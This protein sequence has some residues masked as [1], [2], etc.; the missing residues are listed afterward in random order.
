MSILSYSIFNIGCAFT[1]SPA[2]CIYVQ[3]LGK[4]FPKVDDHDDEKKGNMASTLYTSTFY[5]GGLLGFIFG[6]GL[7]DLY[8]FSLSSTIIGITRLLFA[9][10]YFYYGGVYYRGTGERRKHDIINFT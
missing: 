8:G 2:I 1:Y 3:L 10:F 4:R 6:S 9:F 5:I 7:L